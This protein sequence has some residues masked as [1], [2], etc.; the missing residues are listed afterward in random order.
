[1]N[2]TQPRSLPLGSTAT[3]QVDHVVSGTR[4]ATIPATAIT[5]DG[6]QPAVWVVKRTGKSVGTVA[7]VRVGV[8]GYQNDDVM[9]SGPAAGDQ[10][11]TAGVQ[12]MAPGLQVS[13]PSASAAEANTVAAQ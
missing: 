1:L 9:I 10:V 12:K 5:Q 11:V 2:P 4:T 3:L 6:G 8:Q 7:L 13:L